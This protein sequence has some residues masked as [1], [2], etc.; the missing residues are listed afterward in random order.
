M[1]QE[2]TRRAL[3]VEA[4]VL[5]QAKEVSR[6]T[7]GFDSRPIHVGFVA[8]KVA[9]VQGFLPLLLFLPFG[10]IPPM[11]KLITFSST[12]D[13]IQGASKM[14]GQM[15]RVNFSYHN[16]EKLSYKHIFGNECF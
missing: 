12:S 3:T 5:F 13:A 11:F 10:I 7:L 8:K 1:A 16:K 4:R 15:S 14:L 2:V 6:L 9:L